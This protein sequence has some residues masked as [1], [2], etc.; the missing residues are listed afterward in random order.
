LFT[1]DYERWRIVMIRNVIKTDNAPT[2]TSPYSQGYRARDL[3][4]TAGQVG[5]DPETGELSNKF[6]DQLNQTL[7]NIKGILNAEGATMND[8]I[9]T[10][11]IL[12]D[13]KFFSE[14]NEIYKNYFVDPYPARTTIGASLPG[15]VMV[16]IEA[17]AY[18]PKE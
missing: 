15:K 3:I 13:I 7:T 6:S 17:V 12:S 18:K 8:V 10:T 1:L 5:I 4:Y 14:L 9:K 11:V 16:E 2:P